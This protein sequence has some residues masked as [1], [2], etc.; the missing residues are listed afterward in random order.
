MPLISP[1][2]KDIVN[3]KLVNAIYMRNSEIESNIDLDQIDMEGKTI[4]IYYN[5]PIVENSTN[6]F[7]NSVVRHW[8]VEILVAELSE[9]DDDG[10]DGDSI[11]ER[12]LTI[13]DQ[14]YDYIKSNSIVSLVES[15]E[16][17]E[18]EFERSVKIYDKT[19]TG[20]RLTMDI[21]ID[22]NKFYC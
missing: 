8:P 3:T 18:I 17:Y 21:P 15:I 12:C 4:V 13:S 5:L 16:S 6:S 22:R 9:L 10:D 1:I 20:C 14:I 19:I 2:V 11:R 7:S